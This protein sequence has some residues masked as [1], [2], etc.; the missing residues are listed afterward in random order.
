[1]DDQPLGH[2]TIVGVGDAG[3][4]AVDRLIGEG[5]NRVQFIAVN[6]FAGALAKSKATTRLLLG[7]HTA[8]GLGTGGSPDLGRKAAEENAQML[9]RT[10]EDTDTVFVVYGIGGGTGTGAAPVIAGIG[11]EMRAQ[12]IAVAS[13]PF[14]F[15]GSHRQQIAQFG[16]PLLK[17]QTD[18]LTIISGDNLLKF[19]VKDA[20]MQQAYTLL[21]GALAWG[22]IG[23]LT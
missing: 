3:C 23:H 7:E 22:V 15:E 17:A 13:L 21:C 20:S 2:V 14:T 6:T 5:I 11:K 12:V 19:A 16:L 4:A 1:M 10:L 9:F 18:K 8:R